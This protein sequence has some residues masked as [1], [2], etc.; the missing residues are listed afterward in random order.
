MRQLPIAA[1]HQSESCV[2]RVPIFAGLSTDQQDAVGGYARPVD[3][4][5]G[6][7]LHTAGDPAARLF[8]VHT[9]QIKLIRSLASGRER[10]LRVAEPG[11]VVGEHAFLTG[12]PPQYY[13]EAATAARVCVFTH[14]DLSSLVG[15]YPRIATEMM[16]SLSDRLNSAEHLLSLERADVSAR[17]ADYLLNLPEIEA[18]DGRAV[19]LPLPKKDIASYLGTT[20]ES[21]SRALARLTRSGSLD[22]D[23]ELIYLRD[24]ASLERLAAEA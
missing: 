1:V 22:V 13:A 6:E 20:P 9:G 15:S 12:E 21:L 24:P 2:R 17:L 18:R 3:L 5:R 19:L 23:G 7:L 4:A 16:R 14:D 11:D 10:L 8:V